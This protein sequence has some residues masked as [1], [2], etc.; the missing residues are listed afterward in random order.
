LAAETAHDTAAPLPTQAGV[1]RVAIIEDR[2][3]IRAG[4]ATL[5]GG[6]DGFRCT[7]SYGSMEAAL[8]AIVNTVSFHM[9]RIYEKLQV[10][11]KSEAVARALRAGL[12]A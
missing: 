12:I 4:L 5:S 6:S 11:S 8:A 1:V 2:S 9:K 7:G 10:H 3:E